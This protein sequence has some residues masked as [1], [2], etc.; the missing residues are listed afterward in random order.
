VISVELVDPARTRSLRRRVLRPGLSPDEPLPGDDRPDAVHI[1]ALDGWVVVGT[2]FVFRDP[3]PWRPADEPAWHLRQ[4]A[5]APDRRGEGV[6]TAV[7]RYAA[8]YVRAAGG[9]L[10]WANARETA[11]GFYAAHGWLA[12]GGTFTDT[13]HTIPHRR[14]WLPLP[15]IRE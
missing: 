3:C 13:E 6:G 7:L 10:V 9:V 14:M 5:T 8:D 4:M 15:P 2:C 11:G 1:A 12:E